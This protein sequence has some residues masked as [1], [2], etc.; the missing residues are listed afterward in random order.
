MILFIAEELAFV[1]GFNNL[2]II[3]NDTKKVGQVIL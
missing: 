3:A 2:F 1:E